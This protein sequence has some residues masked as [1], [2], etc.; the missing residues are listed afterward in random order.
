MTQKELASSQKLQA[1]FGDLNSNL[2]CTVASLCTRCLP[3]RLELQMRSRARYFLFM[4]ASGSESNY[5]VQ[6]SCLRS[7]SP[8]CGWCV[9]ILHPWHT[10]CRAKLTEL[11]RW[12]WR[13]LVEMMLP[14]LHLAISRFQKSGRCYCLVNHSFAVN[15]GA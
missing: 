14:I 5:G 9:S 13:I 10:C 12:A 11:T 4:A 3:S 1:S 2:R 15:T 6:T 7:M 8:I